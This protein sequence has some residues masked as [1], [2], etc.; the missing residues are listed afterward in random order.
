M[1]SADDV[2]ET[3]LETIMSQGGVRSGDQV[4]LLVNGLGGTPAMELAIVARRALAILRRQGIRVERAWVGNFMTALEMPGCS[5]TLLPVDAARL[6]RLDAPTTAPAWPGGGHIAERR[7]VPTPEAPTSSTAA[8][9]GDVKPGPLAQRLQAA[10]LAIAAAFEREEAALTELDSHTGDAD[11]GISMVRGATAIRALPDS[12]WATPATALTGMGDAL[13]RAIAGSSGPF[14]AA[15]LLRAARE[16]H[17]DKPDAA[18]WSAAFAAG[19]AAVAELGGARAGDRTMLDAL[20]PAVTAFST[21]VREGVSPA[22][23]WEKAIAAAEAGAAA[24]ASMH[25]RLGRAAYQGERA[26]GHRDAGAAAVLVWMRAI[27]GN[28]N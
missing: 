20:L 4:A 13:R 7:I 16:L 25:P 12:V 11:L 2:A 5:L 27:A 18:S 6:S 24:T 10:A 1:Q 28:L 23:A 14:Y 19:V 3:I 22:P 21:S 15:A 8:S 26:I 9:R 17:S